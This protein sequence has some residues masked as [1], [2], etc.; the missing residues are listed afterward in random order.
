MLVLEWVDAHPAVA[1]D[2]GAFGRQL[3]GLH[4]AGAPTFGRLDR[5]PTTTRRLPNDPCGSWPEFYASCR[6]L[7]LVRLARDAGAVDPGVL[8]DVERL[9]GRLDRLD[10]ADE[11]PARLHGDLW[12]G[13][14]IVDASAR[15]WLID[16]AAHGGH[17]EFDLAM[18]ELFGGFA[19]GVV[20]AYQEVAPLA[21]G[22]ELRVPV[23]QLAPLLTHAIKFSGPYPA[24]VAA[25]VA[26]ASRA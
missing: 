13:N 4:A 8:D 3:A 22:W 10:A 2:E 23:H 11:P 1:P 18:M 17:R 26:A 16:P 6:L 20:A 14:R 21:E 9:A 5:R 24:A 15:S 12:A 25:A 19:P 7:P